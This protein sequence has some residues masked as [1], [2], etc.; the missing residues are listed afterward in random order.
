MQW[1]TGSCGFTFT[2]NIQVIHEIV[3]D[4]IKLLMASE[5]RKQKLNEFLKKSVAEEFCDHFIFCLRLVVHLLKMSLVA[6]RLAGT[7]TPVIGGPM[8]LLSALVSC[9]GP[10][11]VLKRVPQTN[12][13]MDKGIV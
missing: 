5:Q 8:M 10:A 6:S 2:C 9:L 3:F 12:A 1:T 4:I 11:T 13:P 7:W